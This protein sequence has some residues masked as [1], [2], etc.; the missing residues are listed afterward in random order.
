MAG[1]KKITQF[2]SLLANIIVSG[3]VHHL[4]LYSVLT[5][6][7]HTSINQDASLYPSH[8]PTNSVQKA[9]LAVGSGVAAL[10]NPYRHGNAFVIN[11]YKI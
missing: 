11:I 10:Q 4:F 6:H 1:I 5:G 7:Q 8:I 2:L 3:C 9:L